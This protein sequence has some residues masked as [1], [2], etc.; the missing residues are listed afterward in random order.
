[1]KKYFIK[2]VT[3]LSKLFSIRNLSECKHGFEIS[4]V[5]NLKID[6][7][8]KNCDRKLSEL[9][10]ETKLKANEYRTDV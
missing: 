1:M 4:E 10:T 6:P 3:E 5:V 8:C 9:I 7:V 2:K